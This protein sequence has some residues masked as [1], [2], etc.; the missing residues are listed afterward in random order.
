M[1]VLKLELFVKQF[2]FNFFFSLTLL[3]LLYNVKGMQNI[4]EDTD[5]LMLSVGKFL[6]RVNKRDNHYAYFHTKNNVVK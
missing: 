5:R 3:L 6:K 1:C 4:I 2:L